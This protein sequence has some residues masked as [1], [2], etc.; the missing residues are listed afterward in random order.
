MNY[1][2][3]RPRSRPQP[4]RMNK[5]EQAYSNQLNLL[6]LQGDILDFRFEG[7]KLRL[8]D[9]TFYTPDFLVIKPDHFELHEVKGYWE[10]DARVKIKVAA[11]QFPWFLF[12]AVQRKKSNWVFEQFR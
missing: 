8:A 7:L 11:H 6:K 3:I 12:I 1:Q 5:T 4:G 9:K 10:D 2:R